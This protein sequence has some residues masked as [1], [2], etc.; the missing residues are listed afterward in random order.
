MRFRRLSIPAYGPFTGLDLDFSA[1]AAD[2]HVI[3]GR[4]EAGK[5][6]LLR[7]IRDLLYGVPPQTADN[8]LHDYGSLRIGAE[9]ENRAGQTLAVQRRKGLRHTLLDAA[10]EPQAD[11]AL[12]PY[13][14]R[15]DRDFFTAMFG[16]GSDELRRGAHELLQGKGDMG[17][18]LFAA[19]LAGTPIHQVLEKLDAEARELFDGRAW[20]NV[21]IRPAVD[22]YA[23]ALRESRQAQVRPEAWEEALSNLDLARAAKDASEAEL[24]SLRR[25]QDW[26]HRCLAALPILGRL[27]ESESALAELPPLPELPSDFALRAVAARER[28]RAAEAAQGDLLRR[29][30]ALELRLTSLAPHPQV[31]QRE[32]EIN[33]LAAD[34]ALYR[35]HRAALVKEQAEVAQLEQ[36]LVGGLLELGLAPD[37]SQIPDLRQPLQTRLALQ[38]AAATLQGASDAWQTHQQA[39][40]RLVGEMDKTTAQLRHLPQGDVSALRAACAAAAPIAPL[41]ADPAAR[42][43]EL[44]RLARRVA[45]QQA[46]LPGAPADA[47]AVYALVLPTAARLREFAHTAAGLDTQ[48][49][50]LAAAGRDL[51][52][53]RSEAEAHLARLQRGGLLPSAAD[54]AAARS[55]RDAGWQTLLASGGLY[56]EWDGALLA[57]TYP[58]AVARADHLADRLREEAEAIAQAE[59]LRARLNEI[60]SAEA[61]RQMELSALTA[62]R[63]AWQSEWQAAWHDSGLFSP[64]SSGE[65]EAPPPPSPAEMQ[66][67]RDAWL[68][69]HSRYEA[70]RDLAADLTHSQAAAAAA[71]ARLRPLLDGEAGDLAQLRPL[72]EARLRAADQAVGERRSLEQRLADLRDEQAALARGEPELAAALAAARADW[73]ALAGDQ[74]PQIAL[75]LM[76]RRGQLLADFDAWSRLATGIQSRQDSILG[77]E[78]RVETCSTDGHASATGIENQVAQ[79]TQALLDARDLAARRRQIEQDRGELASQRPGVEQEVAAARADFAD[80]LTQA[81]VAD[82][83]A[84]QTLLDHLARRERLLAERSAQRNDLATQARGEPLAEFLTRVQAEQAER[85]GC[86][87]PLD[88]ESQQLAEAIRELEARREQAIQAHARAEDAKTRLEASGDAAA[89]HQQA[90]QHAA[91]RIRHDA[92][93]FLRL[94]LAGQFLREQIEAFRARNQGPMLAR[95]GELFR[96]MTGGSF[97]GLATDYDRGDTPVLVGLKDAVKVP[98]E[99]MSEGS[100]DQ[101]YLSLRLAAIELHQAAHEPMPLILDDL[102]M[103]FDDDRS[104]AILP[105]L[106]DLARSSQVLLFTHHQHLVELAR[107]ALPPGTFSLHELPAR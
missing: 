68:E 88:S 22:A 86:L 27:H 2:L 66:E 31:L 89:Q 30:E 52:R 107:E 25:R 65:E 5:S 80:L 3:Y 29:Q 23:A 8:F 11:D 92:A 16:L 20:K 91:A 26:L 63:H 99:G 64:P 32:G 9:L 106:A 17:Q 15:V 84:L 72:A 35:Q 77:Y 54:L 39:Q 102:F 12:S 46:L 75:P 33:A 57:E 6:S 1:A 24:A 71:L 101:L 53:Q 42:A 50:Q 48:A 14:G 58:V 36:A 94:R 37:I 56:T 98:V 67:W 105:L 103:T 100:R 95:A 59:E 40:A 69:F 97:T 74:P 104:R 96:Q 34:L 10:G 81:G 44:E 4:N 51:A 18:A 90:A 83:A 61:A 78:Q 19:S 49:R 93:R 21:R 38:Q 55:H 60:A 13:L 7:A 79:L 70:W 45:S 87:E 28:L 47:A 76:Q 85:L 82:A 73:Q 62:A 41:V 43:G